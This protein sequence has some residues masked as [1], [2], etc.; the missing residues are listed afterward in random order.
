MRRQ[1]VQLAKHDAGIGD[2]FIA[3]TLSRQGF[4]GCDR[5]YVGLGLVRRVRNEAGIKRPASRPG[6]RFKGRL[7]LGQLAKKL[8]VKIDWLFEQIILEKV[9]VE[10]NPIERRFLI[11]AD[12]EVIGKLETL[13]N[14]AKTADSQRGAS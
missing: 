12:S 2:D 14:A 13:R 4:R 11:D 10:P 6:L 3:Y 7:T 9:T 5:W 1:I 8:G